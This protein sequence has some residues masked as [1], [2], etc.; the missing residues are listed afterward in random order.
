MIT[1]DDVLFG[2]IVLRKGMASMDALKKCLKIQEHLAA[3]GAPKQ[4]GTI[5]ME[6]G[7]LSEHQ[8]Q[9]IFRIQREMHGKISRIGGFEL[10]SELGKG[11]MGS[12]YRARQVSMDRIVAVKI[13]SKEMAENEEFVHRFLRE[14]R[15]AAKLSHRNI[16]NGIE[17]GEENGVYFFAMEFV[18]GPDLDLILE[19]KNKLGIKLALKIGT[20]IAQALAHAHNHKIVHRDVKPANILLARDRIAKLADLGLAKS[21][22]EGATQVTMEGM[23]LGTPLYMAPEQASGEKVDGRS[24]IYSLGATLYHLLTGQPPFDGTSAMEIMTKHLE[25]PLS[26]PSKINPDISKE[27]D[28][29]IMC[30][31]SKSPKDRYQTGFAAADAMQTILNG[32]RPPT[33]EEKT[34]AETTAQSGVSS[35]KGIP[36]VAVFSGIFVI[37]IV[38]VVLF[39]MR[40]RRSKKRHP[41]VTPPLPSQIQPDELNPPEPVPVVLQDAHFLAYDQDFWKAL[42]DRDIQKAETLVTAWL[43]DTSH[44]LDNEYL[45]NY[46]KFLIAI[47]RFHKHCYESLKYLKE[48]S[49]PVKLSNAEG[50]RLSGIITDLKGQVVQMDIG[51]LYER[52]S[53]NTL[54]MQ[55]R[56]Y[57]Y[58]IQPGPL[59]DSE[60]GF[61]LCVVAI[62]DGDFD[63]AEMQLAEFPED[64][65][66]PEM[67]AYKQMLENVLS[68]M[69]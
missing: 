4:I 49:I 9:T 60:V 37:A 68:G 55:D 1:K 12:V 41:E 15:A 50:T 64:P 22:E 39:A 2:K 57:L 7:V 27:I 34:L 33:P 31:L 45:K 24:D 51:G 30:M 21:L 48:N 47:R 32:G 56:V 28:Q 20:Q 69:R 63:G 62:A 25:E 61:I 53:F 58:S 26:P 10:I 16:V 17:V 3:K 67:R 6:Q 8:V 43:A 38:F 13:L 18:E 46:E 36:W 14:A 44:V 5:M 40:E 54:S 65:A 42:K 66:H 11:A 29:V 35:D 59:T 23:T 19:K 52:I